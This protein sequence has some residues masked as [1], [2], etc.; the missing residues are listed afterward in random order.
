MHIYMH[1]PT[2]VL[3][4]IIYEAEIYSIALPAWNTDILY[5]GMQACCHGEAN[6]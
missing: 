3:P 4:Q 2:G 1:K 5:T 6:A